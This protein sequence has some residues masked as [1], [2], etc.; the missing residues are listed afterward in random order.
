MLSI[1]LLAI[2]DLCSVD[3]NHYDI[4]FL[5]DLKVLN[6]IWYKQYLLSRISETGPIVSESVDDEQ[7]QDDRHEF[8]FR[9]STEEDFDLDAFNQL[10]ESHD[11]QSQISEQRKQAYLYESRLMELLSYGEIFR[12][13]MKKRKDQVDSQMS[14]TSIEEDQH[15]FSLNL[16]DLQKQKTTKSD[17]SRV[18]EQFFPNP[19]V[20]K[21]PLLIPYFSDQQKRLF[22]QLDFAKEENLAEEI[23]NEQRKDIRR[24][25]LIY[26]DTV[27]GEEPA[28]TLDSNRDTEKVEEESRGSSPKDEKD[29]FIKED[30]LREQTLEQEQLEEIPKIV[31]QLVPAEHQRDNIQSP[32]LIKEDLTKRKSSIIT[33]DHHIS[34]ITTQP[35]ETELKRPSIKPTIDSPLP[36]DEKRSTSE[37]LPKVTTNFAES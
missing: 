28:V 17:Q 24:Q 1:S 37:T 27:A 22:M 20:L 29:V 15:Q 34:E 31:E 30:E 32:E 2:L 36:T 21:P 35:I 26:R 23:E 25:T 11:T 13:E 3:F 6:E 8:K 33:E 18:I 14:K 7:E 16:D 9:S 10:F 4:K 5:R 19:S 12:G